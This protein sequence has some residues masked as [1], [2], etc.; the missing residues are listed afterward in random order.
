MVDD[1]TNQ[2]WAQLGEQET[3]WAV[4]DALRVWIESY[5]VP[6]ALYVDWKN[7]YKRAATSEND[8]GEKSRSRNSGAGARSWGSKS[9]RPVQR[10]PRGEWSACTGRIKTAW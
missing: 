1:A 6:L 3:I 10:K 9:S 7:L 8:C 2:T 5:G 4:V